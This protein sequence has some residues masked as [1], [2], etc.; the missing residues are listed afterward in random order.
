MRNHL[1]PAEVPDEPS[2]ADLAA[3]EVEWPLIDAELAV[4]DAEITALN[5]ADRGG[6]SPLDW[7]RL[8]R[9]AARVIRAAAEVT[10]T[11]SGPGRVA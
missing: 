4:L 6:P 10:R 8:R 9:A 5:N 3:I 1:A 11:E 2:A 7:R